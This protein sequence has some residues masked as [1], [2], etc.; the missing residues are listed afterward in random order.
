MTVDWPLVGRTEELAFI[1]AAC[2]RAGAGVVIAGRAGVGKT[3]LARAGA[4]AARRRGI[5][6]AGVVGTATAR[7]IAFG[8]F[9]ALAATDDSEDQVAGPGALAARIRAR[10]LG[11][12]D[13]GDT[14]LVVDDA[15]LLDAHSATLVSQ[16]ALSGSAK[17]LLTVRSGEPCPDAVVAIW[18]DGA[19]PRLEVQTLS[20]GE[21]TALAEA[22]LGGQLDASAAERLFEL[23]QGNALYL[24]QLIE[25]ELDSGRLAPRHDVWRWTGTP[26]LSQSLSELVADRIGDQPAPVREVLDVLAIAEPVPLTTLRSVLT[27][28]DRTAGAGDPVERAERSGLIALDA[29]LEVRSGH[30]L[31]AEV[32]RARLG[33]VRARRLRA[34]V[35]RALADASATDATSV[36][37][38]ASLMLDAEMPPD[39]ELLTAAA[40]LAALRNDS[41]LVQRLAQAAVD[42]GG[43]Y[44]AQKVLA[45]FAAWTGDDPSIVDEAFA[46]LE[47]LAATTADRARA[48]VLR[49]S[50]LA[51]VDAQPDAA[52]AVLDSRDEVVRQEPEVQAFIALLDAEACRS[53]A[54]ERA[55]RVLRLANSEAAA[56]RCT[57]EA[58][59]LASHALV[60]ALASAGR[61]A[62]AE[63]AVTTGLAAA[64]QS[65]ELSSFGIAIVAT[66]VHGLCVA[67]RLAEASDL[68][69][70][71]HAQLAEH[72]PGSFFGDCMLGEVLLCQG[73]VSEAVRILR[74]A[75]AGLE[76]YGHMGGWRYAALVL[77]TRAVALVGPPDLAARVREDLEAHV[78]PMLV[79]YQTEQLLAGAAVVAAEGRL[80]EAQALALEV[81]D[82]AELRGQW[83]HAVVA[84]QH[85]VSYGRTGLAGRASALRERVEGPR[86]QAVHEYAAALDRADGTALLEAARA[87]ERFGDLLA[88]GNASAHAAEAF[89]RAGLT[90]SALTARAFAER[91]IAATGGIRT[92]VMSRALSPL[93]LTAREREIVALAAHGLSN[94]AI[95][96]RLV[97]S[98]RTVEGH[99]YRINQK[100]GTTHRDELSRFV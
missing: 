85:A 36:L 41:V 53:G 17:L 69:K 4:D 28:P 40:E 91:M 97:V 27:E 84:L 21:T 10:L 7:G 60:T 50:Q 24:R 83:G 80:R 76:P 72:E 59:A 35:V 37:R 44:R 19:L 30:P 61:L 95:A 78:Q 94:Q 11:G 39:P 8:A 48:V 67:G 77:L 79:A 47:E 32:S 18:K 92:P 65:V 52:I 56:A 96:D 34:A 64:A 22:A 71:W 42:A 75:R 12:G 38:R 54:A 62:E 49:A 33:T 1:A 25:G 74:E 14:L 66:Q 45:F 82:L 2:D 15:H 20:R 3:R 5:R 58:V 6:T 88:A 31:F 89:D 23:S 29:A 90:G 51:M 70:S 26:Q 16:I 73:S 55:H 63:Q 100:L 86:A 46:R 43:G 9:G 87:F 57:P 93:P 81:G 13:I 98:V 68:A 99:L